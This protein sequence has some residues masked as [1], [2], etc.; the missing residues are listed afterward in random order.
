MI[1]SKEKKERGDKCET[2]GNQIEQKGR[3]NGREDQK[4]FEK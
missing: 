2:G 4:W 3:M 1:K